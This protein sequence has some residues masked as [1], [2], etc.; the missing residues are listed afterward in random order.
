MSKEELKIVRDK[1]LT[2][3]KERVCK[4]VIEKGAEVQRRA[5]N[6]PG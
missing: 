4:T 2:A 3:Q 1:A 6:S 5:E